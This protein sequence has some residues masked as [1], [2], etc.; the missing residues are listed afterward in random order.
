MIRPVLRFA[1][2]VLA[3]QLT[4]PRVHGDGTFKNTVTG[5]PKIGA[6]DIIRFSP[7]G[8]L[9]IGDGKGS[10]IVAIDTG[11]TKPTKWGATTVA[12]IDEKL[13]GKLG[14][15]AKGIDIVHMAVNPKSMTAYFAIRK[16]DD[17]KMLILTMDGEGKVA[18]FALENVKHAAI[19]LPKGEKS[20]VSKVTDLACTGD[21]ILVGAVASEEFGCKLYTIPLPLDAQ[22]QAVGFSTETYHVSHGKWET[23]APMT[24][25]MPYEENGKKYVLGAFACTPVVKYPIDDVMPNAKVKGQS[26]IELGSGNQPRIMFTYEKDGKSYVL[27]NTFRFHHKQRPFGWSPYWTVRMELG[28]MGEK[29][30]INEKATLRLAGGKPATER[31]KFIDEYLGV[32]H[33]DRL[34]K[35]R[36]LVVKEEEKGG[37]TLAV[38]NLP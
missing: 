12:K 17:K 30:A 36:A 27:M 16:Q 6:I 1:C 7:D 25:L 9:L 15:N 34:D 8:V 4:T 29:E 32:I 28:L 21:R 14:A 33:L 3:L 5:T 10:Q 11:D 26:V 13:A 24:C 19:P 37:L 2:L 23:R 20:P 18:E 22:A 38:L 31:I 35:E